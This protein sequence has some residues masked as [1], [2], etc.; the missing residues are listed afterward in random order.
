MENQFLS[1]THEV[2]NES[3]ID[4]AASKICEYAVYGLGASS[5]GA[6][7]YDRL[8]NVH[9]VH[10]LAGDASLPTTVPYNQS[11]DN[12]IPSHRKSFE[13]GCLI[14]EGLPT[15]H[16]TE[17][18]NLAKLLVLLFNRKF[19]ADMFG[20]ASRPVD[21]FQDERSFYADLKDLTKNASQMPAGALR[22]N[23]AGSLKT[24][25]F[26]NNWLDTSFQASD[27]DIDDPAIFPAIE[28]CLNRGE[29]VALSEKDFDCPYM[30][31]PTQDGV[32]SAVLTPVNVGTET[33]G[34]LSFALPVVYDFTDIEKKAVLSL[35][36]SVGVSLS[37][38]RRSADVQL[39]LH[40]DVRV[41]QMLTA[42][43]VAQAARHS[44][45][46]NLDTLK[47]H[48]RVV[49]RTV[50]KGVDRSGKAII[51]ESLDGSEQAI[52]SCFKSLDDIKTAIRPPS[53]T[54]QV[55]DMKTLFER[56][57]SQVHGRI[58]KN[59]VDV[60]WIGKSVS[61]D[62]F[63]D[64]MVQVF[65]NLILNSVDAFS[66]LKR[67]GNRYVRVR[68]HDYQENA[69]NCVLRVEDSAGGIDVKGLMDSAE[70]SDMSVDELVFAKDVT[71]KG[72]EGSGWGLYVSRKI[73]NDHGGHMSLIEYRSKTVFEINLL[74]RMK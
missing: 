17:L 11:F 14:V 25:F 67:Q 59:S 7:L 46:A 38:F 37:N 56:A 58:V 6:Y 4:E 3:G 44:A 28:R 32:E 42:V 21:F 33:I 49:T 9:Q 47:T 2:Y 60:Q 18:S 66:E 20:A 22:L 19:S 41:S 15:V 51:G 16:N 40:D 70:S 13:C 34:V 45:R 5:A 71:S 1:L 30:Q 29:Q 43:E 62:C 26:W 10:G 48:L 12:K 61:L 52:K 27:L 57:K 24:L 8:E 63:P 36:N 72:V 53:R 55:S 39:D 54:A 50:A 73:I 74:K 35:A 31:R 64:H 68:L 23:Q 69:P 65:L